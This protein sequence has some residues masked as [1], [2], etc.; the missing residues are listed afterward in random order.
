M[1]ISQLTNEKVVLFGKSAINNSF[2]NFLNK[3]DVNVVILDCENC[4]LDV[5]NRNLVSFSTRDKLNW[6][7]VDCLIT[8]QDD[9]VLTDTSKN[10]NCP[11]F[12]IIEFFENYFKEYNY[13]GL[14]GE[15]GSLIAS[16]ILKY[17]LCKMQMNVDYETCKKESLFTLSEFGRTNIYVFEIKQKM[18]NYLQSPHFNN[19]V[20]F[21]LDYNKIDIEKIK[22]MFLNQTEDDFSILNIDNKDVKEFY[23]NIKNDTAYKS[24]L[25]P[26]SVNKILQ[27]GVSFINNEIYFNIDNKADEILT[28]EFKNLTGDQNKTNILAVFTLLTKYGTQPQEIVENL[29]DF[30]P[31]S[32]IFE[33]VLHKDNITFINDIKNNNKSQSLISFDNIYWILCVDDIDFEFDEFLKLIE[34]FKKIKYVFLLGKYNE[35]LLNVFKENDVEYFIMYNMQ[36]VFQKIENFSD[37][38]EKEEKITV[39]LSSINDIENNNFYSKCS[40]DFEKIVNMGE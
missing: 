5:E 13:V 14:I 11:V 19:I 23:N 28:S 27:D 18:F 16:E 7:E 35:E 24:T 38:E 1:S 4:H 2:I 33:M 26:I 15:S 36:D 10:H 39:L 6:N 34:Y 30:K 37:E 31:C 22:N 20:L 29:Y 9:K 21:D 12:S 3:N 8:N 17:L 32:D 40:E 25:I